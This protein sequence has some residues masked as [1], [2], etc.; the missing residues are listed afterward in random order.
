MPATDRCSVAGIRRLGRARR[1]AG[2][3]LA[4]GAFL[5]LAV[6]CR[7]LPPAHLPGGADDPAPETLALVGRAMLG[8]AEGDTEQAL[9]YFQEAI[10]RD[11]D[12]ET[13]YLQAADLQMRRRK[14]DEALKLIERLVTR[15][16]KSVA[17]RLALARA[18]ALRKQPDEARTA[19]DEALRLEP[20]SGAVH[21]A[22][23][24]LLSAIG[25]EA[26]ALEVL[27]QAA[28]TAV[29]P[30]ALFPPSAFL[31]ARAH[32]RQD[33]NTSAA[34]FAILETAGGRA[35]TN[36]AAMMMLG[37]LYGGAGETERA[38]AAYRDAQRIRPEM[39]GSYLQSARLLLTQSRLDEAVT[40][41]EKGLTTAV[42]TRHL[43]RVLGALYAVRAARTSD[44]EKARA[45][46][47]A[48]VACLRA[49]LPQMPEDLS[50]RVELG[51]LMAAN[52]RVAEAVSTWEP[53]L[54]DDAGL[55]RRF[56]QRL[57]AIATLKTA[58]AALDAARLESSEERAR[59]YLLAELHMLAGEEVQARPLFRELATG[60]PP[61]TSPYIR[62]AT[63][64]PGEDAAEALRCIDDGLQRLIDEPSLLA[65][66]LILQILRRDT[67]AAL[68]TIDRLRKLALM[69][70]QPDPPALAVYRMLA[71][72]YGGRSADA[73]D[74]L[75]GQMD[76]EP[77]IIELY[78]RRAAVFD[79]RLDAG[80]TTRTTLDVLRE[81]RPKDALV[82]LYRG[83]YELTITNYPAAVAAFE[84]V[85]RMGLGETEMAKILTPQFHF[86]YGSALERAG[87]LPEAEREMMRCME[88]DPE[89]T[90]P[91]NYLAYTWAEKNMKLDT[92]LEYIQTA[93]KSE[94]DNG[95]YLD[96]RGW[97]Y[98]KLGRY[99][100]ALTDLE[101]GLKAAGEDA[102]ILDHIGDAL[103]KLGRGKESVER[104]SRAYVLD[105][106]IAGLREKLA[107]RQVDL[108]PLDE[109]A[110][111]LREKKQRD[112]GILFGFEEVA[113]EEGVR[114]PE[115]LP[116]E[117]ETEPAPI[118]GEG[119]V[120]MPTP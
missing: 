6:G 92:A 37:D 74:A 96:T 22:A 85:G 95:A 9:K 82:P 50:V 55:R 117:P 8:R 73:A 64:D 76:R 107:A 36:A 112:I 104:W 101:A 68:A 30:E 100:E 40:A 62:L 119:G 56:A 33:T 59:K 57:S 51:D 13:L 43:R 48:G 99:A 14:P 105:P 78:I 15:L 45:D 81:R 5:L 53:L 4:A 70:D 86:W 42:P 93:L 54:I 47:D 116:E 7:T 89:M 102:T 27:R 106:G 80:R 19:I 23:V 39:P 21:A 91:R 118:P 77:L 17:A 46:R 113:I 20:V 111:R 44:E 108:K 75:R 65:A 52:G 49:V 29:P 38:L 12:A 115:E 25:Q 32:A 28:P 90:D 67:Q 18:H 2:R 87:R 72:Q 16:P 24:P 114:N 71:L 41:L 88:L 83:Y 69:D 3:P 120:E 97:I 66:R 110:A 26:R 79:E 11:P 34:V 31:L 61:E 60:D 63:I 94:P 58:T 103:E 84:E 1:A 10:A 98:F 35:Q 109:D